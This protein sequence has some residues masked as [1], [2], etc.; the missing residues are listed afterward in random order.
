MTKWRFSKKGSGQSSSHCRQPK[1]YGEDGSP[2]AQLK[3]GSHRCLDR[4]LEY[5]AMASFLLPKTWTGQSALQGKAGCFFPR[6]R[7]YQLLKEIL[8]VPWKCLPSA[9]IYLHCDS[10]IIHGIPMSAAPAGAK[11]GNR[12]LSYPQ[13]LCITF[14]LM[15]CTL[16]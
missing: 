14:Q 15:V 10:A 7:Q 1:G 11:L 3:L 9:P 5:G 12:F 2:V 13:Q 16:T 8:L 4:T 6:A